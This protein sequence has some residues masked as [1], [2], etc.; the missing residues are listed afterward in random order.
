MESIDLFQTWRGANHAAVL[1]ANTVLVKSVMALDG[2]GEPPSAAE[3][4][5]ARTLRSVADDLFELI[6]VRAGEGV[7]ARQSRGEPQPEADSSFASTW[8][9]PLE[10]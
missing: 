3:T 2:K 10:P 4:D 9:V 1:A 8:A 6:I 7:A 5:Q